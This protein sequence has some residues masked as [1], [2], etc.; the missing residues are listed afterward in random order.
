MFLELFNELYIHNTHRIEPV[1]VFFVLLVENT[2]IEPVT[3]GLQ[4]RRSPS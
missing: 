4:S 2:G 3:S 1:T